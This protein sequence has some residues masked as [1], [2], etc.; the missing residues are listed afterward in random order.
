MWGLGYAM[1]F[2]IWD[3]YWSNLTFR[4]W[5][6]WGAPNV[7]HFL[8]NYKSESR[9][10]SH[11]TI[12]WLSFFFIKTC[13][14]MS[15]DYQQKGCLCFCWCQTHTV[16]SSDLYSSIASEEEMKMCCTLLYCFYYTKIVKKLLLV[17]ITSQTACSGLSLPRWSESVF[18]L[19]ERSD[20]I[21]YH[22]VEKAGAEQR[23]ECDST[24]N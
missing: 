8:T 1:F 3:P 18:F 21:T 23:L 17:K 15:R 11:N 7:L 16:T 5:A 2:P 12:K 20:L 9:A 14:K 24:Q 4:W 22:W 13:D 19:R 10:A 6:S